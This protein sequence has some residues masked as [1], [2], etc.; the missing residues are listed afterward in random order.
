M[1]KGIM[2][3]RYG[4]GGIDGGRRRKKRKMA[5]T[6]ILCGYLGICSCYDCRYRRIPPWL[7][8]LGIGI[9]GLHAAFMLLT[10]RI[11][12]QAVLASTVPGT[13]ML[14]YSRLSQEKL[15][16]ADG[17]MVIPAGLLQQWERCT[18]EVFAACFLTFLTAVCL[19]LSGKGTKSTKIPFA[20]FFLAAVLILW[21]M[22]A[23]GGMSG[24]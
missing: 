20:P 22:E 1:K 12:W 2:E 8:K 13:V 24:G 17:L 23:C 4:K 15:G 6:I 3:T 19:L 7:L 18:A 16:L 14:L 9:G 5:E 11:A 21:I 10:G